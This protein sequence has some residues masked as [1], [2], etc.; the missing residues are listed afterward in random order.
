M[1]AMALCRCHP[2]VTRRG[3]ISSERDILFS[4]ALGV[5]STTTLVQV[6]PPFS[7]NLDLQVCVVNIGSAIHLYMVFPRDGNSYSF[8]TLCQASNGMSFIYS[9]NT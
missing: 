8:L 3:A 1:F 5:L 7:N 9:I 2:L 6:T 4:R